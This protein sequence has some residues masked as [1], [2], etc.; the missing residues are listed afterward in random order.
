[1]MPHTR[2]KLLEFGSSTWREDL[3]ELSNRDDSH[4]SGREVCHKKECDSTPGVG[5]VP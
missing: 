3:L 4:I 1:M 5:N 2:E